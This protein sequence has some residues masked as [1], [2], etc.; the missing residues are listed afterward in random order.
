MENLIKA[1]RWF[2]AMMLV[3]LAGQQF[4]DGEFRPVLIPPF[5]ARFP[6]EA[7]LVYLLSVLLIV[8]A[9]GIV[10]NIK[11]RPLALGLA[12]LFFAFFLFCYVPYELWIDP[13]GGSLGAWGNPLK[14]SAMA[15][16][17]LM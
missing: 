5:V 2:F 17:A 14:E 13:R 1:G 3:G 6:G 11:S 4:Y 8:A 10:W 7:V 12:G 9:A 16:G 15:G